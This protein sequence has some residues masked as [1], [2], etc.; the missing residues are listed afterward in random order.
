MLKRKDVA[1]DF[2]IGERSLY[3]I[4]AERAVVVFFYPKAFTP[5]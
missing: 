4:L 2:R 5:G 1:P 3:D